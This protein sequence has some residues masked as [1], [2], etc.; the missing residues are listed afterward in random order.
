[1]RLQM[2]LQRNQRGGGCWGGQPRPWQ[3]R[4]L[5][6]MEQIWLS[7]TL[8]NFISQGL[9]SL[10]PTKRWSQASRTL[11]SFL[12]LSPSL[13]SSFSHMIL[14]VPVRKLPG[15]FLQNLL[16]L[17]LQKKAPDTLSD[18][19]EDHHMWA[20][21]T[22]HQTADLYG[23]GY[24]VPVSALMSADVLQT[25]YTLTFN[26]FLDRTAIDPSLSVSIYLSILCVCRSNIFLF[27][28]I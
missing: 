23:S 15:S 9:S 27:L 7:F 12:S 28:S 14:L 16:H 25:H 21:C 13:L 1:M 8:S 17:S 19:L 22:V 6:K 11:G 3:T 10:D 2:Q 18:P 26:P 5:I 20:V 4:N 24:T